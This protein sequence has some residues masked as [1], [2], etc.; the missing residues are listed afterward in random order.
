MI[1]QR[2]GIQIAGRGQFLDLAAPLRDQLIAIP[3]KEVRKFLSLILDKI[4]VNDEY[5]PGGLG[6]QLESPK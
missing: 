4:G 3:D 5:P 2:R 1:N 6:R